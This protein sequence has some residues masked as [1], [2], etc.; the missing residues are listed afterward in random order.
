MCL[1]VLELD[2]VVD[3]DTLVQAAEVLCT[4]H[5]PTCVVDLFIGVVCVLKYRSIGETC[6]R[7]WYRIFDT[8]CKRKPGAVARLLLPQLIKTFKLAGG[9][10]E[11]YASPRSPQ[12][13]LFQRL[14]RQVFCAAIYFKRGHLTETFVLDSFLPMANP[15]PTS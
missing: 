15:Y 1:E 8:I 13:E 14:Y 10:L 9:T 4:E 7:S 2:S 6:N 3:A 12:Y 5:S 11:I